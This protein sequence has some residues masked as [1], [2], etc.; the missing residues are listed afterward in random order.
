M[1]RVIGLRAVLKKM[2]VSRID[3]E[4]DA[5]PVRRLVARREGAQP[6]LWSNRSTFCPTIR[7]SRLKADDAGRSRAGDALGDRFGL[8]RRNPASRSMLSRQINRF[9]RCGRC[10][11]SPDRTAAPRRR[12][13]R[14]PR[15]TDQLPVARAFAPAFRD[16]HGTARIQ[17]LNRITGSPFTWRARTPLRVR[18]VGHQSSC[19]C[20][21]PLS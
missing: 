11:R 10:W 7:S 14:G 13:S 17:M 8:R 12:Q 16:R 20:R 2:I 15:A 18:F 19:S 9:P 6:G 1:C 3:E 4:R 21:L 5:G